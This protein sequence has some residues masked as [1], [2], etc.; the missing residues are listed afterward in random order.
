MGL[1]P[2]VASFGVRLERPAVDSR[3]WCLP[4]RF[5]VG[6][7]YAPTPPPKRAETAVPARS[8]QATCRFSPPLAAGATA[9][10]PNQR[11]R[12]AVSR[13]ASHSVRSCFVPTQAT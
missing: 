4:S 8:A 6:Y 9:G 12:A 1:R 2:A 3:E 5:A 10:S 13:S 11:V 7:E